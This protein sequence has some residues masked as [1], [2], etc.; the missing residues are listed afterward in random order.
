MEGL[1]SSTQRTL[2]LSST[3]RNRRD[4]QI[5]KIKNDTDTEFH[6]YEGIPV[7]PDGVSVD[8]N[9]QEAEEF[10]ESVKDDKLGSIKKLR[11]IYDKYGSGKE[12]DYKRQGR[13]NERFGNFNFG[14]AARALGL[15]EEEIMQGAGAYQ[16]ISGTS[17]IDWRNSNF[18]DPK[19]QYDLKKG[20]KYYE[21]LKKHK[22]QTD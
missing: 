21:Q 20:S 15:S 11:Y 6:K 14:A 13:E 2:K 22:K 19:D 9:I 10:A 3:E 1:T 7:G 4:A 17:K 8:K 5:R 16:V 12:K 18:D